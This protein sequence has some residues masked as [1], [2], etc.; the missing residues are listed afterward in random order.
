MFSFTRKSSSEFARSS[1]LSFY[2]DVQFLQCCCAYVYPHNLLPLFIFARLPSFLINI[3]AAYGGG[4]KAVV[5]LSHSPLGYYLLIDIYS[6]AGMPSTHIFVL[7]YI[8]VS[9]IIVQSPAASTRT[10]KGKEGCQPT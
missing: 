5:A 8:Y 10:E 9:V 4:G 2:G 7:V 1:S 3:L 6:H